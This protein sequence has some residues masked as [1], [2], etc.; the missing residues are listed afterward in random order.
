VLVAQW[1][2]L[3]DATERGLFAANARPP[4]DWLE[5]AKSAAA[6][7]RIPKRERWF[8]NRLDHWLPSL[9]AVAFTVACLS[10]HADI[11]GKAQQALRSH[12]NDWAA[13]HNM[14]VS[15]IESEDWNVAVAHAT[16]AFLMHPAST[17][18][19]NTLRFALE[20]APAVDTTLRHLLFGVGYQRVPTWLSPA[21]WQ[22][23]TLAASLI[24]ATAFTA[25]VIALYWPDRRLKWASGSALA[26][27]AALFTLAVLSWNAYGPS[28]QP[29]AGI[30]LRAVNLSPAPTDLVPEE[31]TSPIAAGTIVIAQRSFL[32][33]QQ[34][35]CG[36]GVSGWIRRNA[37]MPFYKRSPTDK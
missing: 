25:A 34:V 15:R 27:G 19:R 32:S 8:P 28:G 35:T 20:H 7:V 10:A 23:L 30:L 36:N 2:D 24:L 16:A 4:A 3:C 6:E 31:E 21:A 13:H 14:A 22:R 37:V 33:W 5:R 18:N 11:Q 9:A 1:H 26:L 12:W 17:T 29:A